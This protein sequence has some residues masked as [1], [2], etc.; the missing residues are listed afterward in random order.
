MF[1][2]KNEKRRVIPGTPSYPGLLVNVLLKFQM[3]ISEICKLFFLKTCEKL[4]QKL[5]L[6]YQEKIS[7][8]LIIKW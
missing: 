8:Y 5:L 2:F 3:L 6:F 7:V 1:L 4:L